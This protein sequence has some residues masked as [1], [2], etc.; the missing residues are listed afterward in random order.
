MRPAAKF[1]RSGPAGT[2]RPLPKH[3]ILLHGTCGVDQ[4]DVDLRFYI[5]VLETVVH[6]NN[7]GAGPESLLRAGNAIRVDDDR[8]PAGKQQRFV[9]D[10]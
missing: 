4:H 8:C 2:D 7:F 3:P 9:A 1:S 5:T 6:D 10:F